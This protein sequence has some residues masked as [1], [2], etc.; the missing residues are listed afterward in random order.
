MFRILGTTDPLLTPCTRLQLFLYHVTKIHNFLFSNV[1]FYFILN[2]FSF[3]LSY[4][5]FSSWFIYSP[6]FLAV[7]SILQKLSYIY[8]IYPYFS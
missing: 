1:Q 6:N 2:C 3:P 4:I 8:F 7:F 5:L